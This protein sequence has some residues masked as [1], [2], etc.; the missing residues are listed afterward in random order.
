MK[1]RKFQ[2]GP[3]N[4]PTSISVVW[5]IRRVA[6]P[7]RGQLGNDV[8]IFRLT[9]RDLFNGRESGNGIRTWHS[10]EPFRYACS[11]FFHRVCETLPVTPGMANC[12][13]R[14]DVVGYSSLLFRNIET[15]RFINL[16][17]KQYEPIR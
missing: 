14:F 15:S 6:P 9:M 11:F 12:H 17:I 1:A 8:Y 13:D 4:G 10:W 3:P 7:S 5:G 16:H 2:L